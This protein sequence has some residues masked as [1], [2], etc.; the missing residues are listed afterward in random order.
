MI[1]VYCV[2]VFNGF[3]GNLCFEGL[4]PVHDVPKSCA[5]CGIWNLD[6]CI[7]LEERIFLGGG[8]G[9]RTK[10]VLCSFGLWY[11]SK[12]KQEDMLNAA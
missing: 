2:Y 9:E 3:L 7:V 11:C 6:M 8:E 5:S 12:D 4:K 10:L 1:S